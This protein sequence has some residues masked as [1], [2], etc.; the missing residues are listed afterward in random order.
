MNAPERE[1]TVESIAAGGDGV[2]RAEGLVV[3]VPRTAPGD[4]ASVRVSSRGRF[5]RGELRSLLRASP[6]RVEPPCPHYTRDRCGGC[7][8]QH[9]SYDAQRAAKASIV[10][11]ALVRIGRRDAAPP[12]VRPS[13][14]QWRYRRKLTLAMRRAQGRWIAGLH[15]YDDPVRVFALGDCPITDERV[16]ATWRDVLAAAEQLPRA[17]ELRGAV[18]WMGDGASFTLEGGDQW[19]FARQFFDA[20]PALRELWWVPDDGRRRR[21]AARDGDAARAAGASFVQVNE[22]VAAALAE[23]VA[24]KVAAHAPAT[25]VDA[26]AGSGAIAQMVAAGGARVTAIELD[27]DAA[28]LCAERLG[29]AGRVIADAVENALPAA[30]PADVVILNPPRAGVHE[31]VTGALAGGGAVRTAI[32]YVSCNP[33]TLARDIQRLPGYRVASLLSFDMFPQTAHVE[34]VCEL[35]PEVA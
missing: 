23:Y 18:R 31:R 27:P 32:V 7:Q 22:G 1:L 35:L 19:R 28:A 5:A 3:F 4:V 14:L 8:L 20:V 2:A 34:T 6:E 30:L 11:D 24:S 29:S 12:E 25:V 26:Y 15:P 21:V 13:P 17:R 9:M 33:A 16:V 10:R